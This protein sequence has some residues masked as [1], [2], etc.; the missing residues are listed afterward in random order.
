MELHIIVAILL[1]YNS[2]IKDWSKSRCLNKEIK[3]IIDT[4]KYDKEAFG[5]HAFI[6]TNQ[7]SICEKLAQPE[8]FDW[9]N[10][11]QFDRTRIYHIVHC[12]HWHCHVSAVYSMLGH[13]ASINMYI[14]RQPFQ[15]HKEVSIP[16]S[17]GSITHGKCVN[18]AVVKR[19]GK[20]YVYT[21]WYDDNGNHF[22]KLIPLKHYTDVPVEVY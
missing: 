14:L 17:D 10:Y 15:N 11:H 3:N 9:L 4:K 5:R 22:T 16:R 18:T 1:D 6:Q 13:C 19:D 12:R 2:T 21:Y 7:C 20:N 8:D